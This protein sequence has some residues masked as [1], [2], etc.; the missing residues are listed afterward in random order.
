MAFG[1]GHTGT[2]PKRSKPD[3]LIAKLGHTEVM[4]GPGT[5]ARAV[6]PECNG[7]GM[8]FGDGGRV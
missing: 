4:A 2:S 1:R 3:E 7:A 8:Q 6:A 5:N